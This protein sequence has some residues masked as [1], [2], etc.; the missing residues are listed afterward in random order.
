MIPIFSSQVVLA[1]E[2]QKVTEKNSSY[3][4]LRAHLESK[5]QKGAATPIVLIDPIPIYSPSSCESLY[6]VVSEG[7][8]YRKGRAI[9]DLWDSLK[10]ASGA[11]ISI[12]RVEAGKID[13]L[14]SGMVVNVI[15]SRRIAENL[16][17]I[18]LLILDGNDL[19]EVEKKYPCN[20][21]HRKAAVSGAPRKKGYLESS[22]QPGR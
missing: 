6:I 3:K 19:R 10:E 12:H 4:L 9:V 22:G 14:Y 2:F 5:M 13:D 8:K 7:L 18:S 1:G 21:I 20:Y 15:D 17:G 11:P 16:I